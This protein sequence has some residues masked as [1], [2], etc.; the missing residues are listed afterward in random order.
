[1]HQIIQLKNSSF[2]IILVIVLHVIALFAFIFLSMI[3]VVKIV[4]ILGCLISLFYVIRKYKNIGLSWIKLTDKS[5]VIIKTQ[6][7]ETKAKLISGSVITEFYICLY[8]QE[9]NSGKKKYFVLMRD[10]F[11]QRNDYRKLSAWLKQ[12]VI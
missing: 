4:C 9:I 12:S 5:Q 3:F 2:Y 10:S 11:K 7:T 8:A 1:M 6:A